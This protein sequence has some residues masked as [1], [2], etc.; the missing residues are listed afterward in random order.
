[1]IGM[2]NPASTPESASPQTA[3]R[4]DGWTIDRQRQ[5]CETL[6]ECGNVEL[7]AS[8]TGMSRESAYRLRRRAAGRAFALAWDAALLLA[9]QRMIDDVIEMAFA[10]SVERHYRD[11]KLVI[12]KRRRDPRGLLATIERLGSAKTLGTASAQAVAQDFEQFLDCMDADARDPRG[13][14]AAFMAQ[15]VETASLLTRDNLT[16]ARRQLSAGLNHKSEV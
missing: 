8:V 3:T 11:G 15:R 12:E 1:M 13:Y 7:A 2:E 5:F 6:A 9:R 16:A 10:G 14:A 4:H